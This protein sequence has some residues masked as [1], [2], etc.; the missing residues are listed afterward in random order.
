MILLVP[1]SIINPSCKS[2]WSGTTNTNSLDQYVEP[3]TSNYYRIAPNYYYSANGDRNIKIR[4]AGYGNLI[5]CKS[6]IATLPKP[7]DTDAECST[8]NSDEI[9]YNLNNVCDGY[10]LIS[11]CPP[12]YFSITANDTYND[13]YRCTGKLRRFEMLTN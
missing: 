4:G 7:S 9:T 11:T 1:R 6:T 5:V 13:N 10:S 2:D 12:F 3:G 8:I